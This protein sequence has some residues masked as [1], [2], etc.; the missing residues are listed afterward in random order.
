MLTP[1]NLKPRATALVASSILS[2][3]PLVGADA[4]A[5]AAERVGVASA[6]TPKATSKPPGAATRTLKIGKSVFYNERITTSESGVVQVLLVDGSTFTVGP[7]SNLVI[8]KFVYNPHQGTG[9]MTASLSKGALRFVGGKL[10]KTEPAVKIKTPAGELTIRGG[11]VQG[12]VQDANHAVFAFV[13]GDY[14]ALNRKGRRCT[15]KQ[16]G[17]LFAIGN[18]GPPIM[19]RTTQADTNLILAAVSGRSGATVYKTKGTGW[20]FYYGI[21]PSGRYPDQ[22]FIRE[23]YY[24]A[25]PI[26]LRRVREPKVPVPHVVRTPTQPVPT[27]TPTPTRTTTP[28]LTVR[29]PPPPPTV[30]AT[31]PT[32]TCP[33][34]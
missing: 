10:S 25:L 28:P 15:L 24:D 8:D 1:T 14:L 3:V 27:T 23:Q 32:V 2:I 19:R 13:F 29:T 17:N 9:E 22:P 33:N 5:N 34:C 11:I 26:K 6:V 31:P 20:P 12:I 4:I 7:R 30:T 21:Q 18:A 16:S